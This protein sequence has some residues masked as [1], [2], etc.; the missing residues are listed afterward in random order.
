MLSVTGNCRQGSGDAT[1]MLP[2]LRS[3]WLLLLTF[4]NSYAKT[5]A[6]GADPIAREGSRK[7]DVVNPL[8]LS[9][10]CAAPGYGLAPQ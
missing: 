7:P 5:L 9:C 10:S 3:C 4:Q 2:E 1:I 8:G 6:T